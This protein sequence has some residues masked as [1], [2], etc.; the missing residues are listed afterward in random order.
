MSV[1]RHSCCLFWHPKIIGTAAWRC[2]FQSKTRLQLT[3]HRRRAGS[4]GYNRPNRRHLAVSSLATS[5]AATPSSRPGH[6]ASL[7]AWQPTAL[8]PAESAR[9]VTDSPGLRKPAGRLQRPCLGHTRADPRT[10]TYQTQP[11]FIANQI[12][13]L[14]E[15]NRSFDLMYGANV[16][17]RSIWVAS[18]TMRCPRGC[19]GAW[20]ASRVSTYSDQ[21]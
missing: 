11:T 5:P 17:K 16:W 2:R 4:H 10:R 8:P 20:P 3:G 6:L 1:S 21:T 7:R 19:S 9:R 14:S 15:D 12:D 13:R 18:L